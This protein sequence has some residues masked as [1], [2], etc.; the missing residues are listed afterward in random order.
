MAAKITFFQVGNGDMTLVRL[1]DTRVTTILTDINIRGSADDPDDDMPDVAGALRQRLMYDKDQ[2]PFVDAFMLSHPDQDH[3]RG[4]RKH[5]WLGRPEDYP[6]DHL[7][8]SERRIIIRELW[9]SP[10]IFRR[11]SVNHTLCDDARAFN[12]EARR[13][14]AHWRANGYATSGN[15][16]LIMGE[17]NDDKTD[18]L[19]AILIRSGDTFNKIDGEYSSLFSARLLA[20]AP[21]E[22]DQELETQLSKNDSSIV[23]NMEISPSIFSSRKTRFLTGGDARVLI[24]E[25]MWERFQDTPEVLEYDLLLAPHHCSWR[26]LSYDSWSDLRESAQLC[27]AARK[28]LGQARDGAT[29]ISSSNK[30]LDDA[31]DPPSIRAK[32]EYD[33]ITDEVDGWFGC[34]GDLKDAAVLELE[35]ASNGSVSLIAAVGIA[36]AAASTAAAAAPRAGSPER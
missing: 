11:R 10:L 23:M 21:H 9:S 13:R 12:S 20:P 22:D 1:A 2:R 6:D 16:I 31:V 7:E 29:I 4:L 24:W 19:G 33:E 15:R 35:V 32:R 30:I 25:R 3:C 28:A 14:V 27:D 26:S 18:D 8:R 5:F 17:D 36:S 34:T